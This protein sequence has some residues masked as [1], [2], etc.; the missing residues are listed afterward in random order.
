MLD[1]NALP[2]PELYQQLRSSGLV[3][4]LF[5]L[6]RDEDLGPDGWGGGGAGGGAGLPGDVTSIAMIP[7]ETRR[8][9]ARLVARKDGV[10]AGMACIDDIFHPFRADLDLIDALPDGTRFTAGQTLGVLDGNLRALL[11]T[12]RTVLNTLS[13][14]SGIAAR[15]AAFAA[16]VEGTNARIF[17][18]RKTTPGMRML[19]KY[20]VRCGGGCCH[21]LGL[22]DAALFKDNHLAGVPLADLAAFV[23]KSARLAQDEAPREGLRFIEV[24]VDSLEQLRVI[25]AA[26]GCG[27][28]IVLLDNMGPEK[29]REAVA[30]RNA[31][32]KTP[33]LEASGGITEA[34]LR[35]IASTGVDRIS[36]GTL[37]H[38][39]TWT[40]IGLDMA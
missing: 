34:N 6:A 28:D 33:Q 8:A 10:L 36:L 22:Y 31:A 30:I 25:I 1:L 40:D 9:K 21:R 24:E 14:L 3:R 23:S 2:L 26:G 12:E 37:T 32:A 17:D 19:E 29:L 18:T 38:G 4:R 39:A 13:R 35:E 20:A 15:T 11:A 7:S 5:E 27:V 16:L